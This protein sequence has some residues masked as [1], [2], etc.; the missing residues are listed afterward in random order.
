MNYSKRI[1]IFL[2]ISVALIGGFYFLFN[3]EK[4][5]GFLFPDKNNAN[6]SKEIFSLKN[7][8]A[9]SKNF[10]NVSKANFTNK[11]KEAMNRSES[12]AEETSKNAKTGVFNFFKESISNSVDSAIDSAGNKLGVKVGESRRILTLKYS[13]K[14]NQRAYFSIKPEIESEED[15][16]Y[17]IDWGEGESE[18]GEIKNGKIKIISHSWTNKGD[19]IIKLKIIGGNETADY[20]ESITVID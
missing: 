7:I 5:Y 19:Y 14:A 6:Q 4:T 20:E 12:L 3:K 8:A 16:K 13:V 2:I 10:F 1:L 17:E 18:R 9:A 11:I 15:L